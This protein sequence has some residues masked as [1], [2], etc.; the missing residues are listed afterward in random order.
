[1][2]VPSDIVG[3]LQGFRFSDDPTYYNAGHFYDLA[4]YD[5]RG[6][7]CNV[8]LGT[9]TFSTRNSKRAIALDNTCHLEFLP[10]I[11]WEG[12]SLLIYDVEVLNANFTAIVLRTGAGS[13]GQF[14]Y[15]RTQ[16]VNSTLKHRWISLS[17]GLIPEV[18]ASGPVALG[19]SSSQASRTAFITTDGL[20]V[21]ESSAAAGTNGSNVSFFTAVV[22]ADTSYKSVIGNLSGVAGST[23]AVTGCKIHLWEA[24]FFKGNPYMDQ[25]SAM[26]SLVATKKTEYGFA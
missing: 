21:S 7:G 9:P 25:A 20:T 24:H 10:A 12:A 1:M 3:Y 5:A 16:N 18:T 8:L 17:S 26:A 15:L 11:P 23:T 13:A 14:A 2:T 4:G 22:I 19:C 6:G